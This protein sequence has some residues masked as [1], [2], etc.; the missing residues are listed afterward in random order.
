MDIKKNWQLGLPFILSIEANF[1][2]QVTLP[3]YASLF[4]IPSQLGLAINEA[5]ISDKNTWDTSDKSHR[6]SAISVYKEHIAVIK[7]R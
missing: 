7:I 6:S 1:G 5:T 2:A 4:F 3:K